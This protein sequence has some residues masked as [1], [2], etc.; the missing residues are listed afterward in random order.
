[1]S[2]PPCP[3]PSDMEAFLFNCDLSF[4]RGTLPHAV[5]VAAAAETDGE[6]RLK[7][8]V[9]AL[10]ARVAELEGAS[11]SLRRKAVHRGWSQDA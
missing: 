7:S 1:M 2:R 10:E 8:R 11:K 5:A 3:L 4:P 6:R 9:A